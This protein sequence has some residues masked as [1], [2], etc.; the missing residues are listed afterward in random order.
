MAVSSSYATSLIGLL[1]ILFA[2]TSSTATRD[3]KALDLDA[4][5]DANKILDAHF[6]ANKICDLVKYEILCRDALLMHPG[7]YGSDVKHAGSVLIDVAKFNAMDAKNVIMGLFPEASRSQRVHLKFCQQLYD[8]FLQKGLKSLS[9]LLGKKDYTGLHRKASIFIKYASDC[10]E[11]FKPA[12]SPMKLEN[13]DFFNGID[14]ILA[15][16][17]LLIH[18]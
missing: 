7:V 17:Y 8:H 13:T 15:F 3:V 2:I 11:S 18:Q 6:D 5:F 14:M 4:H 10:E 1:I 16:S 9:Q 12:P